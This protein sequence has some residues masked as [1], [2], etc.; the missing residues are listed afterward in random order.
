MSESYCGAKKFGIFETE[1]SIFASIAGTLGLVEETSKLGT[2]WRRHPLVFLVEAADDIC[3]NILDI[4]DGFTGGD[5]SFE[6]VANCLNPLAGTSNN[7]M[8]LMIPEEKISYMRAR[9]IGAAIEACVAAF[10][11]NYESIMDGTFS[12]SL[13][14]VS[15]KK[16]E[17]AAIKDIATQRLFTAKRKTE[18]EVAGRN[19][20]YRVLSGVLPVYDSLM[21]GNWNAENL[22]G[23]DR[24][25][26]RALNLDLRNIGDALTALHSLADFVSGM[27]DRYAVKTAKMLTGV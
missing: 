17:F 9:G 6:L 21:Q 14:E 23:Y 12:S 27:T 11:K 13:I 8:S 10:K 18:L 19:V 26:V 20:I 1:S 5:L 4:E 2:W 22:K 7:D 15:E 3:Y 24:Q 16:D 25:V